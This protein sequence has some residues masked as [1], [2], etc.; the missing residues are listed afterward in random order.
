MATWEMKRLVDVLSRPM[1]PIHAAGGGKSPLD[2][3]FGM[4]SRDIFAAAAAGIRGSE[5][6]T[7]LVDYVQL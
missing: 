4:S 1:S 6:L 5:L 2:G 7:S 3:H